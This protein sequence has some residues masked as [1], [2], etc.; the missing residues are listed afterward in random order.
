M[1]FF[2]SGHNLAQMFMGQ[3]VVGKYL[4]STNIDIFFKG[5]IFDVCMKPIEY[6]VN[7]IKFNLVEWGSEGNDIFYRTKMNWYHFHF[8]KED[9]L[10]TMTC[11]SNTRFARIDSWAN[12]HSV[13]DMGKEFLSKHLDKRVK[14]FD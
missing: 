6:F 4:P 10:V 11:Y 5:E 3:S 7:D 13:E 1:A 14:L 2:K 9:K 8:N 12:L